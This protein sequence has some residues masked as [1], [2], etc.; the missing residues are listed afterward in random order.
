MASAGIRSY[1][2][3]IVTSS[4]VLVRNS[5]WNDYHVASVHLDILA[6][7]ATEAKSGT[8]RINAQHF[9]RRAVIMRKGINSVSPRVGPVVLG[10][11]FFKNGRRI[12]GLGC[13]CLVIKQQGQGTIW[14]N[15]VVLEIQLGRLNEILLWDPT[16][17][18][19]RNI[20]HEE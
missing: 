10:E 8:T 11:T 20:T 2:A 17:R 4:D 3:K 9:M 12:L 15:A 6:V 5:G 1:N 7:L 16:W 18:L 19:H 13:D 14:E